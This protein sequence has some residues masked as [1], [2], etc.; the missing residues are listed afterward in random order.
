MV[1]LD[2]KPW[3]QFWRSSLHCAAS[4]VRWV[5]IVIVASRRGGARG[6]AAL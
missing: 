2:D 3:S 6:S 1:S 5:A 4:R